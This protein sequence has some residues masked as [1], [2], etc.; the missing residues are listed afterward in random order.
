MR[1]IIDAN[2]FVS[3]LLTRGETIAS[4]FSLWEKKKFVCLMT[5]EIKLEI[6]Q[7]VKRFIIKGLISETNGFALLRR[8]KRNC[9][10]VE[11]FSK[12]EIT[13]NKKD[14]RYLACALDGEADY[15][16]TGDK[17]HLLSLKKIGTAKIISPKK[18][19]KI[20]KLS[21]I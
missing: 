4:I 5:E 9:E 10:L 21:K 12:I 7:V 1:V 15:L 16:V 8:L 20:V 2:L 11:S 14:N 13:P 18:F 19:L 6:F 17:K 3:F